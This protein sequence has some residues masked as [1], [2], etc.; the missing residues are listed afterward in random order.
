MP[1][2]FADPIDASP[3]SGRFGLE[4]ARDIL[5]HPPA[6][7]AGVLAV[8]LV[9][10]P[11]PFASVLPGSQ[12]VLAVGA[13]LALALTAAGLRRRDELQAPAVP[14]LALA[15]VAL[16]AL[17]QSA[18]WPAAAVGVFS[19]EHLRLYR[20]AA[21]ALGDGGAAV[22]P[23]LSLAAGET[24]DAALAWLALAA[25]FT[26]AALAGRERRH[27]RM[28]LVALLAV[29]LF[30]VLY[31]VRHW[32]TDARTI[33]GVVVPRGEGRLRATFV[34]PNHFAVY[35]EM[36]LP[37]VFA[38]GWWAWRRAREELA[39]ERRLVLVVAPAVLWLGLFAA[40]AFTGSRTG[41]AAAAV[42]VVFQGLLAATASRRRRLA[43]LGLLVALVGLGVVAAVGLQQGLGRLLAVS[44]FELTWGGRALAGRAALDLWR[45]FP[46]FGTG[47]GTF[48][49]AFPLVQ[50][51]GLAGTWSHLHDD[52][53]ELL[54]T[55]GLA[56]AVVVVVGVGGLARR[57]STVLRRG[58]RSEDRAAALAALG[59]LAALAIHETFDFGLT[60][61][62]NAFTLAV[63]CGVAC[64]ARTTGGGSRQD[65]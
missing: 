31:G 30:E 65:S 53:L 1:S 17:L 35:L 58:R 10:A 23:S 59:A 50:P 5:R 64:A 47:L 27:R 34:N 21:A 38:L 49:D 28:L 16:L 40:L 24:R 33:W 63:L 15:A 60:T 18:P 41:L 11:L 43:P 29:A 6:L 52:W 20:E 19:P 25:C 46:L 44:S 22:R 36:V 37:T 42:A 62:A 13:A 55:T 39:I 57:L 14:A 8:L 7:A 4:A 32:W 12:T 48:Q 45:H 61:S 51:H 26:A 56:G 3:V 54:L 2:R 9:W